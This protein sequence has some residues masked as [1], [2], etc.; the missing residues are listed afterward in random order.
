MA[1]FKKAKAEQA[2]LK[3]GIYGPPGSG[4]TFT[5]LLIAEGLAALTGKRTAYVDTEH[6]TDFYCQTVKTR[7]VHPEAF[8]FDAIYTRSITE[9]AAAIKALSPDEYSVIVIDSITHFWE[10]VIAAYSGKLTSVGTIPMHAWGKIKK[11]YK[12]LMN[13]LLSSPM[14]FII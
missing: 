4:K 8:D 11:P 1:G 9:A 5:S 6:G 14:H 3:L 7:R 13:F 10:A 2:A 12:D